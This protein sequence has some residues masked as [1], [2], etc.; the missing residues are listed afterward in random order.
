MRAHVRDAVLLAQWHRLGQLD[1]VRLPHCARHKRPY[2]GAQNRPAG[3]KSSLLVKGRAY[4][5]WVQL[6]YAVP[7][8]AS[9]ARVCL[10]RREGAV[11][12]CVCVCQF[13][14]DARAETPRQVVPQLATVRAH[15]VH[16]NRL[17]SARTPRARG[18]PSRCTS[19]GDC[20]RSQ[21]PW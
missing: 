17:A 16:A 12:N 18:G 6:R 13:Q 7:C 15:L 19:P 2:F 5:S 10:A 8:S 14:S 3:L 20:R 11:A 21:P 1:A 9:A 4:R